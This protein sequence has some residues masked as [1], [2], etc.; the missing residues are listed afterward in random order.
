MNVLRNVQFG[1]RLLYV[2]TAVSTGLKDSNPRVRKQAVI[3]CGK[4]WSHCPDFIT[5]SGLIDNL[6]TMIRD[7]D[8]TVRS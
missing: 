2:F 1:Y 5:E 4:A 7:P 6:Y 3:G 8:H